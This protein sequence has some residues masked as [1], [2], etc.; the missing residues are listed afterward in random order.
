[1]LKC[2][3]CGANIKYKTDTKMFVCDFCGSSYSIR[4]YSDG[5]VE[6]NGKNTPIEKIKKYYYALE[7]KE[8]AKNAAEYDAAAELFA[9]IGDLFD[10]ELLYQ[11]CVDNSNNFKCE[12]NYSIACQRMTSKNNDILDTAYEMFIELGDYKD[13][14]QKALE[15]QR[16]HQQNLQQELNDNKETEKQNQKEKVKKFFNRLITVV[17]VAVIVGGIFVYKH[18]DAKKYSRENIKLNFSAVEN[19]FCVESGNHYVFSYNVVIEN[20]GKLN[21]ESVEGLVSF[22]DKDGNLIISANFNFSNYPV[23]VSAEE[24]AKFLWELS[25]YSLDDAE[26]LYYT[27]EEDLV[28]KVNIS[29]IV[30][31]N[32]KTMEYDG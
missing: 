20:K 31:S 7:V 16:L 27:A 13:S 21:I 25:V 9:E 6:V 14:Q 32:G 2:K 19:N 18:I 8:K 4:E 11:E 28:T 12:T 15:C 23:A 29:K 5:V 22:E 10:A 26:K 30:F 24:K 17:F 3:N 1:M